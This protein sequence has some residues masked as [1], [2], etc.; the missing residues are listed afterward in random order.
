MY[1]VFVHH[2][3]SSL[4]PLPKNYLCNGFLGCVKC[5]FFVFRMEME[6]HAIYQ[7]RR[8]EKVNPNGL[9][10]LGIPFLYGSSISAGPATCH[11]RAM[12]PASDLHL[13]RRSLRNLHGNPML[14]ATGPRYL[15][16][17]GQKCL[18][19]RRGS[20]NQK[21]LHSDIENSKSQAEEKSLGEIH[22]IPYEEDEYAKGPEIK[23]RSNQKSRE[24]SE[25]P[26]AVLANTCGELEPTHRKHWNA[27]DPWME[28]KA[29]DRGREKVSE[30]FCAAP[31]RGEKNGVYPPLAQRSLS[32]RYPGLNDQCR[33]S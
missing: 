14:V 21:V 7:Q 1:I 17:W 26:S 28:A 18:H 33:F 3:K 32:G 25:K 22:V 31:A 6:M 16:G 15:E 24:I 23:A 4:L 30:K 13:H 27:P 10:G 20:G 11:H 5:I 8:I 2:P 29:W 9:A 12:L 19:L